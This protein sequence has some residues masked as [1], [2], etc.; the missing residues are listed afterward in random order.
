MNQDQTSVNEVTEVTKS[1][2]A[3]NGSGQSVPFRN[4]KKSKPTHTLPSDRLS[5]EKQLEALRAFVAASDAK[6]GPVTN[7]EAGAVVSMS[8]MTV[9]V[10]NAFFVDVGL[11]VRSD[12]GQFTPGQFAKDYQAAYVWDAN[13]A[14]AKLAP[15][16]RDLWF[17][18]A[19]TPRLQMRP[20][21]KNEAIAVLAEACKASPEYQERLSMILDFLNSSG[22]IALAGDEV[23]LGSSPTSGNISPNKGGGGGDEGGNGKRPP[24]ADV[25]PPDAPFIYIDPAKKKKVVLLAPDSSVTQKEFA[26]IKAW[27]DLQFFITDEKGSGS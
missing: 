10:T 17:A 8:G 4:P 27:F 11:L 15:A 22:V 26:R 14:G 20:L 24:P 18:K 5:C 12:A 3:K 19:L 6:G 16:F 9:V 7:E 21:T 25:I 2:T 13:I 1:E 23:R